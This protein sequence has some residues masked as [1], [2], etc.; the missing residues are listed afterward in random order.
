MSTGP[1]GIPEITVTELKARLDGGDA[2]VIIDV[3]EPHEWEIGNLEA[4][5]ATLRPMDDIF[6]WREELDPS[7]ETV[8]YCRTGNRSA[9]IVRDLIAAGFSDVRNLKGGIHAWSA[10]IDPSIPRY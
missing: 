9:W 7:A 8:V 6:D 1:Q 4:H 5:G 10:E 3:R 2:P